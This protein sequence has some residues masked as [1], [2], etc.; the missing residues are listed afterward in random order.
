MLGEPPPIIVMV[1]NALQNFESRLR[2][3]AFGVFKAH[4]EESKLL[5]GIGL[6]SWDVFPETSWVRNLSSKFL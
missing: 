5:N 1:K 6:A 4:C 2:T 3:R